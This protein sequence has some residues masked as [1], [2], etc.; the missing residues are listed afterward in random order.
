MERPVR[1]VDTGAN[2][3]NRVAD[4]VKSLNALEGG[5][6]QRRPSFR[7][8][9]TGSWR[10]QSGAK[11][12]RGAA[13][14]LRTP[15]CSTQT[16]WKP[17][18]YY[19]NDGGDPSPT[20][21]HHQNR[22]GPMHLDFRLEEL[23]DQEAEQGRPSTQGMSSDHRHSLVYRSQSLSR[24]PGRRATPERP[25]LFRR[26]DSSGSEVL[27][28]T[29]RHDSISRR[30][31]ERVRT[32]SPPAI[33]EESTPFSPVP[34]RV[35]DDTIESYISRRLS[36]RWS[37]GSPSVSSVVHTPQTINVPPSTSYQHTTRACASP[38]APPST[39]YTS[40]HVDTTFVM[41]ILKTIDHIL[42]DH[43][44]ALKSVITQS[45]QLLH[46]KEQH[47]Q[48]D[49]ND[50]A[51]GSLIVPITDSG[52]IPHITRPMGTLQQS[53][54]HSSSSSKSSAHHRYH[55]PNLNEPPRMLRKRTSSVPALV[56]LIDDTA[57]N[58]RNL[59][60][61]TS[62]DLPQGPRKPSLIRQ[63]IY[64]RSIGTDANPSAVP[65]PTPSPP[66]RRPRSSNR[67]SVAITPP[68][69]KVAPK[70]QP[71]GDSFLTAP[72]PSANLSSSNPSI[73]P[74]P[75]IT[76][77]RTASTRPRVP[78]KTQSSG[79]AALDLSPALLEYDRDAALADRASFNRASLVDLTA[80][81][82]QT[83]SSTGSFTAQR[84]QS[85]SFPTQASP[86]GRT[87]CGSH[88]SPQSV[89]FGSQDS[90]TFT[91]TEGAESESDVDICEKEQYFFTAS[92]TVPTKKS[93]SPPPSFFTKISTRIP[94]MKS[95]KSV[96]GSKGTLKSTRP[97]GLPSSSL[98]TSAPIIPAPTMMAHETQSRVEIARGFWTKD[99]SA[100][101]RSERP[102]F[103]GRRGVSSEMS[104]KRGSSIG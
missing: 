68:R 7:D 54:L 14:A 64:R 15:S 21:H 2:G 71:L 100:K 26:R 33:L 60:K 83:F 40:A 17:S 1:R 74:Q 39:P 55:A 46:Q 20:D 11:D 77:V 32:M 93:P 75:F 69:I 16:I 27:A 5:E 99:S 87:K 57:S 61:D 104:A 65:L 49:S 41:G 19:I 43:T 88:S 86:V 97:T 6:E 98:Y 28:P 44:S 84:P 13:V 37:P 91:K 72:S 3:V 51:P 94:T 35:Q 52:S 92:S 58:F 82:R 23:R 101:A 34:F 10:P 24:S 79:T 47:C 102:W 48:L 73:S 95:S 76:L 90:V 12:L 66:L 85:L 9:Q 59:Y 70:N 62:P 45:E 80:F 42:T 89:V 96:K 78:E 56:Q 53:T 4:L 81:S 8:S 38:Y 36:E 31:F 67:G 22:R 29:P 25:N 103:K 30:A 50:Q 63:P 18:P